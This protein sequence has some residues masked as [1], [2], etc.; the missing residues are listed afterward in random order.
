M[1]PN[2]IVTKILKMSHE[3]PKALSHLESFRRPITVIFTDIKGSTS[4]YEKFGDVAGFAMVR[5]CNDMLGAVAEKHRGRVIKTIGDSVMAMFE[6]PIEAIRSAI[7][8]QEELAARNIHAKETERVFVRIGL[9]HGLGIVK[10]DDVF[11]D[12]VNV[13]SRVQSVA[14]PSQIV[15]SDSLQK[16]VA[17]G[18]FETVSLGRFRLKGKTDERELFEVR[19]TTAAAPAFATVHTMISLSASEAPAVMLYHI[20][21][22]GRADLQCRLP[23]QGITVGRGQGDWRFPEDAGLRPLH[24]RFQAKGGQ[25]WVHNLAGVGSVFV[26]LVATY[27][28]E[29]DDVISMGR[30]LLKFVGKPEMAKAATIL[31]KPLDEVSHLLNEAP[32]EFRSLK[33]DGSECGDVYPLTAEE[34]RFGRTQGTHIFPEDTLMSRSHARVYHR[35]EDFFVEDLQTRNGTFIKVRGKAPVPFGSQVLVG[36]QV[37]EI[38]QQ[39][40]SG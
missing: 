12:V 38:A 40:R 1:Q 9:H 37:F 33:P 26:K 31:A 20:A 22:D 39:Q 21:R 2:T 34:V 10:T 8:M 4:Y 24:A 35:G 15:I 11:G 5:Q 25:V 7:A 28:L 17:Q 27:R 6:K 18:G 23:E 3:D 14:L 36:R 32:A 13:A 16:E 29:N 19:W 30:H